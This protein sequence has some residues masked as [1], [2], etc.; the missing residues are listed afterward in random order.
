LLT[1]FFITSQINNPKPYLP[2]SEAH[3]LHWKIDVGRSY[4][5]SNIVNCGGLLILGS[6]GDY[7]RNWGVID[8]KSGVYFKF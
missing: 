2:I 4:F 8:K 3:T 7:F 1:N 6:N 5:R